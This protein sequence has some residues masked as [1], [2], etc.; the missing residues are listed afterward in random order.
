MALRPQWQTVFSSI[1]L[2]A[3]ASRRRC[4]ETVAPG[5]RRAGRS[6]QHRHAQLVGNV[7]ALL[8]LDASQELCLVDQH[9]GTGCAAWAAFTC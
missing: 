2:S 8:D 6:A 4:R 5:N 1:R 3:S 7:G 9:A